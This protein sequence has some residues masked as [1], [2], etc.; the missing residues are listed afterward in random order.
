MPAPL[1]RAA[2]AA[3]AAQDPL[4]VQGTLRAAFDSTG[5]RAATIKPEP[6]A[7]VTTP[8]AQASPWVTHCS[9]GTPAVAEQRWEIRSGVYAQSIC[10]GFR[11]G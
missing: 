7:C 10:C 4:A 5:K 9:F 1:T 8:C 6:V 11:P 2:A 3:A